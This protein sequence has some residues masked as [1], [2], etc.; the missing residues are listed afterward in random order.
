MNR[1]YQKESKSSKMKRLSWMVVLC[2]MILGSIQAQNEKQKIGH[3]NT[4]NLM[5][6]MPEIKSADAILSAFQDSIQTVEGGMITAFE[7][8]YSEFVKLANAGELTK[9]ATERKQNELAQK[10]QEIVDFRKDVQLQVMK[11][12]QDLM[13]P[14]LD[15]LQKAIDEVAKENGFNYIFDIGSGALLFANDSQDVEELVKKKLGV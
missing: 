7:K 12:R 6:L 3:I 10:Q 2:C 14:I 13:T 8:E 15:K 1:F 9:V 11:K 5:E 4:G